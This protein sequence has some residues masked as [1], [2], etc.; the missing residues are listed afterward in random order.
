MHYNTNRNL[1]TI[2]RLTIKLSWRNGMLAGMILFTSGAAAIIFFASSSDKT[3]INELQ[4][5]FQYSYVLAYN[6]LTFITI[7]IA[8]FTIRSQIDDKQMHLLTS[9]PLKRRDIWLGT[10]LGLTVIIALVELTLIAAL[11]LCSWWHARQYTAE[12]RQHAWEYY[13]VAKRECLPLHPDYKELTRRQIAALVERQELD[14]AALGKET[15]QGIYLKLRREAQQI[16][17]QGEKTWQF[18][19]GKKPA[20][21]QYL[22]LKYR[23]YSEKRRVQITGNWTIGAPGKKEFYSQDIEAY[24]YDYNQIKIPLAQIPDSGQFNV[25]FKGNHDA[26]IIFGA[27]TG[28]KIYYLD[29]P[30]FMNL[31]K[32]AGAQ[33][34]HLA[35]VIGVG[36]ATGIAFTFPVASFCSIVLYLLSLMTGF[37]TDVIADLTEAYRIDTIDRFSVLILNLGM[38]LVRGLQPPDLIASLSSAIAIPLGPL[39]HSWLPALLLYGAVTW[40]AGIWMLRE[41]E[42]DKILT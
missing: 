11:I 3:L 41:K 39:L 33:L 19:L 38:G 30:W 1:L 42:L 15:W 14:P 10:W 31:I 28:L 5:R 17:A 22:E 29:S 21:G 20:H 37:F 23:F 35:V 13:A 4:L 2:A 9:L 26:E 8:C 34:L 18:D 12:E 24:P 6:L 36:L 32:A 25:T 27:R 40:L 16:P 7:A